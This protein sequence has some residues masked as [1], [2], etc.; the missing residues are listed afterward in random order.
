MSKSLIKAKIRTALAT[1]TLKFLASKKVFRN[2]ALKIAAEKARKSLMEYEMTQGSKSEY[3]AAVEA[4]YIINLMHQGLKNLDKGIISKDYLKKVAETLG[5]GIWGESS[6]SLEAAQKY[7]QKYAIDPPAFCTISPTQKCNLHCLGCY[8]ASNARTLASLPYWIV[9]RLVKEMRDILGASFI[10]ISGGEPFLWKDGNKDLIS[11]AEEF[12]DMFFLVYTNGTLLDEAM[13]KKLLE[14]GNITP[15]ISVEGY[16]K[17]TDNRR[18]KGIFNK[19]MAN[20]ENLK[21]YGV[22]FG[23]SV[24]A[25]KNN[26]DILLENR[27][28]E[29]WFEEVGATYMWMF[30]LMP[31]GRAKDTMSL[32]LSPEDRLKLLIKW[33]ELLF[34]R[35]YFIGDFWNSGAASRGCIAYGRPNGYFYVD[36]NGNIMPCVFVPYYK[37]NLYELYQNGKSI[38][39]ALMSDYF[40]RGRKWQE[41]YGYLSIP[42]GNFFAPC[43]IRDNH[44]YFREKILT[45]DIKPEDEYARAALE[46]PEYYQKMAEFDEKIHQLTE[47]LWKERTAKK[48]S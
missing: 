6:R 46:D 5:R 12:N 18:G 39:E 42:P 22:A 19:I 4:Q 25:T 45:S 43:S 34:K 32:V 28:Y 27:F 2:M 1:S 44:R 10:V 15:A 38:D 31:I 20:I 29:Y 41:E 30:H 26:L 48:Y 35:G 8:A 21:K 16:E 47:P 9:E 23:V 24:T 33:E 14:V 36:W 7:R 17:E 37:D 3:L 13:A 11:L 40:K